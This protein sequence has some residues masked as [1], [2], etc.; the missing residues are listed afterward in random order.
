MILCVERLHDFCVYRGCVIFL[1]HSGCL[2]YFCWVFF[3][4]E[5][6]WFFCWRVG[7]FMV[8]RVFFV[9][10]KKCFLVKRVFWWGKRCVLITFWYSKDHFF[11]NM[12]DQQ[13]DG[14]TDRR[15]TRLLELLR[16]AKNVRRDTWHLTCDMWHMTCDTWWRVNIL[17]KFQLPSSYVFG[18]T[19]SW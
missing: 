8:W 2:I 10:K 4:G 18:Y 16:A 1:T 3:C 5:V 13:T 17:S 15:T 9:C 7:W 6:A 11:T 19:V 14:R 12:T